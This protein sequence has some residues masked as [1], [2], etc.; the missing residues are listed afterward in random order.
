MMQMTD[1]VPP[2]PQLIPVSEPRPDPPLLSYSRPDKGI[3]NESDRSFGHS[4]ETVLTLSPDAVSEK[5]QL[6]LLVDGVPTPLL[7]LI[8]VI[9][10]IIVKSEAE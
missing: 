9:L 5:S 4:L 7:E 8:T 10:V 1:P 6:C 2:S 3:K